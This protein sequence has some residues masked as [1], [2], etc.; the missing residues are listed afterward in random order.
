MDICPAHAPWRSAVIA[1]VPVAGRQPS[2]YLVR[3]R[4]GRQYLQEYGAVQP[5]RAQSVHSSDARHRSVTSRV[6]CEKKVADREL[7]PASKL[8]GLLPMARLASAVPRWACDGSLPAIPPPAD[9]AR[10]IAHPDWPLARQCA[11]A[12]ARH[13]REPHV[14]LLQSDRRVA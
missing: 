8:T 13:R 11:H 10:E 1:S 5:V 7:L 12:G 14:V 2:R 3:C 4:S 6:P 9:D